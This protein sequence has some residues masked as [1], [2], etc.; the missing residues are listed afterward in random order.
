MFES[1]PEEE[2]GKMII[3][4]NFFIGITFLRLYP[5]K[6]RGFDMNPYDDVHDLYYG[7]ALRHID[8]EALV[9]VI[10]FLLYHV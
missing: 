7:Q 2:K 5:D 3:E 1:L 4:N 6:M 9:E 10:S 8:R